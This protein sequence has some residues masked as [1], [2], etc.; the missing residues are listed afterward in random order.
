MRAS[1]LV[2]APALFPGLP[3]QIR[4]F[5]S[6]RRRPRC[7]SPCEET[8]FLLSVLFRPQPDG[9][10]NAPF[11]RERTALRNLRAATRSFLRCPLARALLVRLGRPG[12]ARGAGTIVR[13]G[14]GPI[15][16][17]HA[18][19]VA[20]VSVAP[21]ESLRAG[22]RSGRSSVRRAM[23]VGRAVLRLGHVTD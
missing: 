14:R 16:G 15:G 19:V 17:R 10:R 12:S 9:P 11:G 2:M 1:A 18:C 6:L 22:V 7:G 5:T 8:L 4:W 23:G 21:N 20:F 13:G 3:S